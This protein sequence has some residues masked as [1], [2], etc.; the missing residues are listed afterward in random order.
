ENRNCFLTGGFSGKNGTNTLV[1]EGK[2]DTPGN[3]VSH[4]TLGAGFCV[5]PTGLSSV[6]NV[7]G[8]PGPGPGTIRGTAVG[9]P[10]P[11]AAGRASSPRGGSP[12]RA[13]TRSRVSAREARDLLHRAALMV[14]RLLVDRGPL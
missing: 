1:A 8:L 14:A 7:A 3:D 9:L 5:G 12:R 2:E 6:D 11:A 4:P 10:Q 13:G